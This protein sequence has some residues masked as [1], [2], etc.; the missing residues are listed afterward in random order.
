MNGKLFDIINKHSKIKIKFDINNYNSIN[1]IS[2]SSF[3][4]NVVKTL[5]ALSKYLILFDLKLVIINGN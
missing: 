4:V 2:F 1:L 5:N 3:Q